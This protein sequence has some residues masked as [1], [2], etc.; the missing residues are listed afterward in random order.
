MAVGA[1]LLTSPGLWAETG[2]VNSAPQMNNMDRSAYSVCVEGLTIAFH[3]VPL[4]RKRV[5][6]RAA[7]VGAGTGWGLQP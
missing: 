3:V 7:P 5:R 6:E 4:K 2:A 1:V